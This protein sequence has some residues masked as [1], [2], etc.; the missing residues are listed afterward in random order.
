[1]AREIIVLSVEK[2]PDNSTHLSGVFWLTT[3]ASLVVPRPG[4]TSAVPSSTTV[5]WGVTSAELTA[6]QN[7][8]VT[9][10][11]WD[12]GQ[13]PSGT[14][15]AQIE[16]GLVNLFNAAQTALNAKATAASYIGS[17]FDSV[18]GWTIQ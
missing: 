8:T 6:L 18:N 16:T 15:L 10:Q 11:A 2:R 17:F 13:V 4:L 12:S 9:E 7:G 14:T 3:P 1:M 5:S